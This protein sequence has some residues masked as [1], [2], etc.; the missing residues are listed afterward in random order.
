MSEPIPYVEGDTPPSPRHILA[1]VSDDNG[2]VTG[3]F[4]VN[5]DE[6]HSSQRLQHEDL[7]Q[8]IGV[9]R[10]IWK[11]LRDYLPYGSFE[12]WERG[13]LMDANPEQEIGLWWGAAYAFL[14]YRQDDPMADP[15][16]VYRTIGQLLIGQESL[17]ESPEL[18][19]RLH[20]LARSNPMEFDEITAEGDY[21]GPL[22][23]LR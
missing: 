16:A 17:V 10:W 22:V 18:A 5:A 11:H 7:G 12:E 23:Y 20:E 15:D 2:N 13:F 6:I 14:Q 9:V 21:T 4:W 19:D 8:C 3:L 1:Q